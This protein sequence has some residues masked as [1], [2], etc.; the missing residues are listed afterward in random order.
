[1]IPYYQFQPPTLPRTARRGK[2]KVY[3][4]NIFTFDIETTSVFIPEGGAAETYCFKND[5]FYRACT[6]AA[7]MYIWQMCIDGA[8]YFGRTWAQWLEFLEML[9]DTYKGI[10]IIYVHNLA[11]EFA[12][13]KSILPFDDVFARQPHKPIYARSGRLEFRCSLVLTNMP[14]AAL[15][16]NY[17]LPVEKLVGELDY[18]KPRHTKTPLT[19]SE[20][21]YCKNDV[22]ILY[23]LIAKKRREYQHIYNIPYTQTGEVRRVVKRLLSSKS[24]RAQ[25]ADMTEDNATD[26]KFLYRAYA[27]GY[28]HA[29]YIH[30]GQVLHDVKSVDFASSYPSVMCLERYPMTHFA[31][32]NITSFEQ[33]RKS[34]AYLID[35]TFYNVKSRTSNTWMSVSKCIEICGGI[36]DNGRILSADM[37]RAVLTDVDIEIFCRAY[38]VSGYE[39]NRARAALYDYLPRLF[40]EYIAKLY[41]NKTTLKNVDGKE[42]LYMQSKQYV[43]SLYGMSVTSTIRDGVV[44]DGLQFVTE[45]LSADKI[46]EILQDNKAKRRDFLSYAWGVWVTAYARRNLWRVML[47]IGADVVYCDTDSIKYIGAHDEVI[48]RYNAIILARFRQRCRDLDLPLDYFAPADTKGIKHPMGVFES[49]G[50]YKDFKTLGA[51][52]YAYTLDSDN[53]VHI[54]VS[55]VSKKAGALLRNISEFDTGYKFKPEDTEPLN[56]CKNLIFYIDEQQP[57]MLTDYLGNTQLCTDK[58]SACLQP[59]SYVLDVTD[60]YGA[61]INHTKSTFL[62]G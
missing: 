62:E 32:V 9:Q 36:Y 35:V 41:Q 53:T 58:S 49:D 39:I 55:G 3:C 52:K 45:I 38:T 33:I 27:G 2:N 16:K 4:D 50:A 1:M 20:I 46:T 8:V 25:I 12:F 22:L 26:F 43:N 44:F 54:T 18:H 5:T 15:P 10:L 24:Y 31:D 61:L 34:N 23:H 29:N 6:K 51:K 48:E 30:A 19:D 60:E 14:L 21:A 59:T 13:I 57:F 7:T 42:L 40:V 47:D 37:F 17:M 28:T 11:F 56:A